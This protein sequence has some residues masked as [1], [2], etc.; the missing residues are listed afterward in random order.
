MGK[1]Y[2]FDVMQGR[3]DTSDIRFI[4]TMKVSITDVMW[5]FKGTTIVPRLTRESV[6]EFVLKRYPRLR[7]VNWYVEFYKK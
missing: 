1:F 5:D 6:E 3:K 4:A 2:Y 7:R